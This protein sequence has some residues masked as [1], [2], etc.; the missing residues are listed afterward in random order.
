MRWVEVTAE[1]VKLLL[2]VKVLHLP[3]VL[4]GPLEELL[5]LGLLAGGAR[6]A[7]CSP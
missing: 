5:L 7:S 6:A 4:L 3:P 1:N 2:K